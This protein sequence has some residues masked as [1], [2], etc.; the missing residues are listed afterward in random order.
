ML[1][2]KLKK[3]KEPELS[4][5]FELCEKYGTNPTLLKLAK[6]YQKKRV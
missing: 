2:C 5:L 6:A 4:Y 1:R 3:E